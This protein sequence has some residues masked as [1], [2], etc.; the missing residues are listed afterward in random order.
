MKLIYRITLRLS[1]IICII[2]TAWA[3]FFYYAIMDE[4][5]DEIDDNLEEFSEQIII[6]ALAGKTLSVED[7][8]SNNSYQ[9][10]KISAAF[11]QQHN[12][13][14]Y[15]DAMIFVDTKGETEPARILKTVFKNSNG[16]FFELTVSTPTIEKND[17]QQAIL[18]WIIFLYVVL[19]VIIILINLLIYWSSM[20][21]LYKLLHWLDNYKIGIKN[22]PLHNDTNITEFRKLN[23]AALRHTQRIEHDFERQQQF[24]GN[25]SH[26]L[27]TPLAVC[28]N[29]LEMLINDEHCS[30]SQLMEIAK[31]QQT[32]SQMVRINKTLL[33]LSKIENRQFPE[34]TR[35]NFNQLIQRQLEDLQDIY[36]K[37]Q[38]QHN[39]QDTLFVE[40]NESLAQT[41]ISN[42][43]RNAFVH[44]QPNG[45]LII[46]IT[47]NRLSIANTGK[48]ALDSG[49]IFHRFYQGSN[50][51]GSTGLGLALV[52]AI[53]QI[54][55]IKINYAFENEMHYFTL[56]FNK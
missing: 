29:R 10:R 27:Q 55:A 54:Y 45:N 39:E 46:N 32:L 35:I 50:K 23:E 8:N 44:N 21:P 22:E 11:A 48:Q 33:L 40:M 36:P 12:R 16:E 28:Q 30:E 18:Y 24:I 5:T 26:E 41:L 19:L 15:S 43:L 7:N 31:V 6:K 9:I 2:L 3:F 1:V 51:S 53:A 37:I 38:I 4:V 25:A 49:K 14:E 20:K 56:I 17:L 13:I 34:N 52:D 42:L 47:K